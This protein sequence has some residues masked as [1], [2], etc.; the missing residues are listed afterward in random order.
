MNNPLFYMEY[1]K[2]LTLSPSELAYAKAE[3]RDFGGGVYPKQNME[4]PL[5]EVGVSEL[6][7]IKK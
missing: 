4:Q 5:E 2:R 1:I 3:H 7:K 6:I